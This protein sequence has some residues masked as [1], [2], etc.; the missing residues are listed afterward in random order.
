MPSTVIKIENLSKYYRLGLIG[1]GT[2]REDLGRWVAKMRGK[3]DP[4]LKIGEQDHGN[5]KDGQIWALK[6][7]NLEVKAGEILGIIGRNGAGKST[8]LKI[9][10][11]I[12]AP[13]EGRIKINGRVG[14]LLE[15]GTGFHPELTGRENIYLNGTILGMSHA[16]VSSKL[17]EIVEFA[18]MGKFLDTPVKRYSSGM[19]VRLAFAVAAHLEPEILIIDEVLAVGDTAFQKKCMGKMKD[20]AGHGR[21]ILFVSHNMTSIK[22][23]C[24]RAFMLEKGAEY[25]SGDVDQVVNKYLSD[26][27]KEIHVQEWED[28][29]DAPGN[30]KVRVKKIEVRPHYKLGSY[31]IDT[32]TPV[33]ICF[34]FWTYIKETINLSMVLKKVDGTIVFATVSSREPMMPGLARFTCHIPADL[35]NDEIYSVTMM[36][37]CNAKAIHIIEE[38][39]IFEVHDVKRAGAWHG[40]WVGVVRPKLPWE[41]EA[42]Q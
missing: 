22:S 40:K 35:L 16:E 19:R 29:Q 34:E 5:R 7:I 23:L 21:T 6:D 9:L 33:D 32:E 38:G 24:T 4:L 37:V 27:S 1:G 11:K 3:P 26:A 14:S 12:T 13:T 25:I 2:L 42:V 39:V 8:L 28:N 20:V 31:V 18:E 10:S 36:I 30:S 15:V 41:Y 17:E